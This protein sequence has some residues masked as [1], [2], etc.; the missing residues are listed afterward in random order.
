M[1]D[2]SKAEEYVRKLLEDGLAAMPEADRTDTAKVEAMA[3]RLLT[4]FVDRVTQPITVTIDE[5]NGFVH[6]DGVLKKSDQPPDFIAIT[7]Q[8]VDVKG[9]T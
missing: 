7:L 9:S 1:N 3:K 5:A 2:T 6:V 8:G 4:D